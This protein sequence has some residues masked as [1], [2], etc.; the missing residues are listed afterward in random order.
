M[1]L[2]PPTSRL[3]GCSSPLRRRGLLTP[4]VEGE[5]LA[6]DFRRI[7]L[8]KNRGEPIL[9]DPDPSMDWLLTVRSIGTEMGAGIC[10]SPGTVL[11]TSGNND[12]QD[13]SSDGIAKS[14]SKLGEQLKLSNMY[15]VS[16]ISGE[17]KFVNAVDGGLDPNASLKI[18]FGDTV[19]VE[20]EATEGSL[21][22]VKA[23]IP[24]REAP[25]AAR[26]P[27]NRLMPESKELLLFKSAIVATLCSCGVLL[28]ELGNR[29]TGGRCR[30]RGCL[31]SVV[32][33]GAELA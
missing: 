16:L 8:F 32:D 3:I 28:L 2:S 17:V 21:M 33:E 14:L 1:D 15:G 25:P 9:E 10:A 18:S 23:L 6:D 30:N 19:R 31:N 27:D 29:G 22:A 24:S 11:S 13:V 20:P 4:L 7:E 26:K 12:G 5:L